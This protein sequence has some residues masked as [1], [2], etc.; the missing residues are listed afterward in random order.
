MI[1]ASREFQ[2]CAL[3]ID[4]AMRVTKKEE[5]LS[6]GNNC[7]RTLP[8]EEG[9]YESACALSNHE[10]HGIFPKLITVKA[11]GTKFKENLTKVTKTLFKT[12]WVATCYNTYLASSHHYFHA[13]PLSQFQ[14]FDLL[15]EICENR[16]ILRDTLF[17]H[18]KI[19][20]EHHKLNISQF[21]MSSRNESTKIISYLRDRMARVEIKID[22][23]LLKNNAAH[24]AM[25]SFTWDNSR[26]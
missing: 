9:D 7:L 10:G 8:F 12:L 1:C 23:M 20:H 24:D 21:P 16:G 14:T 17:L 25:W 3:I 5:S 2:K 6:W 15:L 4:W 19:I 18:T 26:N 13:K 11:L 22:V